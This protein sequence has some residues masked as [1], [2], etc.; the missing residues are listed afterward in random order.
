[1]TAQKK[2]PAPAKSKAAAKPK[3]K[4]KSKANVEPINPANVFYE[5]GP[6]AYNPRCVHNAAAWERIQKA[7]QKGKGKASHAELCAVLAKHET[8][9]DQNHHDFIAWICQRKQIPLR[10]IT[11]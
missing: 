4:A 6:G 3:A 11:K 8:K 10:K 9:P 5:L 1:M 2:A 7:I